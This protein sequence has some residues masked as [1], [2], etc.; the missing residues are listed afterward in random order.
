MYTRGNRKFDNRIYLL[1]PSV[2]PL[3]VHFHPGHLRFS[4]FNYSSDDDLQRLPEGGEEGG[5]EGESTQPEWK[6]AGKN[7]A[8]AGKAVGTKGAGQA[9]R[10]V[11]EGAHAAGGA[12]EITRELARH[13]A[14]PRF[15]LQYSNDS[16]RVIQPVRLL[17]PPLASSAALNSPPTP[18]SLLLLHLCQFS[19]SFFS[20]TLVFVFFSCLP[21]ILPRFSF[22]STL[23]CPPSR[24][25]HLSLLSW[26]LFLHL[27]DLTVCA[28]YAH[29]LPAYRAL[30]PASPF[31]CADTSHCASSLRQQPNHFS[32][33]PT[34]PSSSDN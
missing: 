14:N 23:A 8:G 6:R 32:S 9:E 12:G 7:T 16:G 29:L 24:L 31:Y 26:S 13:I 17:S 22:F 4:V 19:S 28:F 10:H 15:G 33:H 20:S 18:P 1:I 25:C 27:P 5:M 2:D 3:V 11:E 21:P 30:D 34:A